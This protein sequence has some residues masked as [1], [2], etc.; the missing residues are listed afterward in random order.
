MSK[1]LENSGL[2][3][4]QLAAQGDVNVVR[5]LTREYLA[6]A[7]QAAAGAKAHVATRETPPKKPAATE[8]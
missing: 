4:V 5:R 1:S 8:P 7:K 2:A 3:D 6:L